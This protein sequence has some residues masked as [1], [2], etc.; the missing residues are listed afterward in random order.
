MYFRF[1]R[2]VKETYPEDC[3]FIW[4]TLNSLGTVYFQRSQLERLWRGF[5]DEVYCAGFMIP[6]R[7]T[8]EKFG[9]WLLELE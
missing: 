1:N 7:E 2:E 3:Q 9:E 8:V 6:N 4:D 5:S